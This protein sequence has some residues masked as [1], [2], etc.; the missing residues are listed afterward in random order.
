MVFFAG[1][2]KE[3]GGEQG[4]V[5]TSRTNPKLKIR[6]TA[7]PGY[8]ISKKDPSIYDDDEYFLDG[9][10]PPRAWPDVELPKKQATQAPSSGADNEKLIQELLE[11]HRSHVDILKRYGVDPCAKYKCSHSEHQSGPSTSTSSSK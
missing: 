4:T 2:K 9:W 7:T 8:D 3:A 10:K 5:M 6:L 11:M 1:K